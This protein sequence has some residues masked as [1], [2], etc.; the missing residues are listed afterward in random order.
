M[1]YLQKLSNE[2]ALHHGVVHRNT[3]LA[4]GID[5]GRLQ[6]I[7]ANGTL[8]RAG[9]QTYVFP[10]APA[11]WLQA[12]S[13]AV[14]SGGSRACASHQTA[15]FLHG[16]IDHRP[17]RIEV[18]VPRWERAEVD[19][20]VHESLDLCDSDVDSTSGIEVTTPVRT[21]VDLGASGAPSM[22]E[23][24]LDT[25]LRRR[26]FTLSEVSAFMNRVAKRGRRGVGV[27][28]PMLEER[29]LWE[30]LTESELEDLFRRAWGDRYPQPTPQ[31]V[32][33]D[34]RGLFVCRTDFAFVE[35]R[36]RVELDSE[37]YHMDSAT[38]G[39]DRAVQNRTELLGW[40]TFRYTWRDLKDRPHLV[41]AEL[42][43]AIQRRPPSPFLRGS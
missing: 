17:A 18:V 16:L 15:A 32:I 21:V 24:A 28:R 25:G 26:I 37:A 40:Q 29:R 19:F 13:I 7:V 38:F 35:Q 4:A 33:R 2:A 3:V 9:Y 34:D 5:P 8:V 30:G 43:T 11:T 6:R 22:V 39:R 36:I 27:I 14:I 42:E 10:G 12:V 23:S 1:K 20:R 31:Y 41:V